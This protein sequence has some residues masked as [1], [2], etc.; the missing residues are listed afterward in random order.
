M[1]NSEGSSALKE[2]PACGDKR[3]LR[4]TK[5]PGVFKRID[6]RGATIGYVAV[7]TVAGRQRK[8]SA[9]TYDEA[10]RL[11]RESEADRDRGELPPRATVPFLRYL[12]EWLER[13]RGQGRHGFRD[14]TREEYRRLIRAYAHRYFSA[15]LKLVEVTTYGLARFL[16]WLADE[17]EQGKVLSDRTIA[18]AVNPLRRRSRPRSARA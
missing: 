10:R 12:D 13:Y 11:K 15:R 1:S 2:R 3:R 6:G 14:S 5:T 17:T 9:R 8:R 18:N 16:D 4:K 7:I